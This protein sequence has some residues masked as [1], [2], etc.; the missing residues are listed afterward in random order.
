MSEISVTAYSRSEASR[1]R[2]HVKVYELKPQPPQMEVRVGDVCLYLNVDDARV[3]AGEMLGALKA[4]A[5]A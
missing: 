5:V 3:L 4:Q 2:L 1:M